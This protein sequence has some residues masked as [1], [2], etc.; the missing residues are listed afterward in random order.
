MTVKIAKHLWICN[1]FDNNPLQYYHISLIHL[2]FVFFKFMSQ[3]Q[4]VLPDVK[5]DVQ[6]EDVKVGHQPVL[7]DDATANVSVVAVSIPCNSQKMKGMF[8]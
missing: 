7:E 4:V 1:A 5:L 2:C 3:K 8:K 6:A